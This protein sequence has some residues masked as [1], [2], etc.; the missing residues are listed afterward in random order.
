MNPTSF[1]ARRAGEMT[2]HAMSAAVVKNGWIKG[3]IF[4]TG[5]VGVQKPNTETRWDAGN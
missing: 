5:M 4:M 1:S 2:A 3:R